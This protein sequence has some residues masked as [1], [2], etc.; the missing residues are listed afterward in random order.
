M[1]IDEEIIRADIFVVGNYFVSLRNC[2]DMTVSIKFNLIIFIRKID[3]A[4]IFHTDRAEN[5]RKASI[6][7]H[8]SLLFLEKLSI[9]FDLSFFFF[10]I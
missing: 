10:D 3:L 1:F 7:S 2:L 6:F 9:I 8:K 5:I 4:V